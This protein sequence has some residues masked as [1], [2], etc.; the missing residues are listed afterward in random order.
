MIEIDVMVGQPPWYGA[1]YRF[2][3]GMASKAAY[4]GLERRWP[5]GSLHVG[6]YRHMRVG[7]DSE[8]VMLSVVGDRREGV[9][10][11]DRFLSDLGAEETEQ[12]LET[13]LT[14][15][16]RRVEVVLALR[17]TGAEPGRYHVAHPPG[18]D[19]LS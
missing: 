10:K 4:L 18:G 8:A 5:D 16:K 14:L 9:E 15:I 19:T 2:E 3:T 17:A 11:A 12:H 13:W 6:V 7:L 1:C